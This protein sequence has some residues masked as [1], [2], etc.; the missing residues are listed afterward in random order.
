MTYTPF[1]F[2]NHKTML[3]RFAEKKE[4]YREYSPVTHVDKNDPEVML[5]SRA[6]IDKSKDWI[7]H[8]RFVYEYKKISDQAG[9]KCIALLNQQDQPKIGEPRLRNEDGYILEKL[10]EK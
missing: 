5:V 9:G 3:E 8:P 10:L 7:H 4:L 1:G 6:P 2:P